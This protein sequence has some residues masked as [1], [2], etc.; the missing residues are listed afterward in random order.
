M[1]KI[2]VSKILIVFSTC[3]LLMIGVEGYCYL[4]DRNSNIESVFVMGGT[5]YNECTRCDEEESEDTAI[6]EIERYTRP[7][8]LPILN[9]KYACDYSVENTPDNLIVTYYSVLRDAANVVEDKYTGCGSIGSGR[10]EER[11]VGKEC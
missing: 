1:K 3:C 10:S 11:R 2:N 7:S 5:Y 4:N 6:L 9:N 8:N